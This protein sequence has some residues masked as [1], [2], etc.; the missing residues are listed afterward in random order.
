MAGTVTA[1]SMNVLC[2]R[3]KVSYIYSMR[4]LILIAVLLT[5]CAMTPPTLIKPTPELV[6][7]QFESAAY[8]NDFGDGSRVLMRWARPL[9]IDIHGGDPSTLRQHEGDL[10]NALGAIESLTGISHAAATYGAPSSV[11]LN[12]VRRRHFKEIVKKLPNRPGTTA[13]MASTSA[14][15]AMIFG[16]PAKGIISKAVIGVATDISRTHRRH[17]IPEELMQIMGLPGDAC[18]YRP[19]LIC[20]GRRGVFE[21]QPADRLMLAVLYD[22]ALRPGM[23]KDVAMPIARRLIRQRWHEY[24]RRN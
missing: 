14:C 8:G 6:A 17:C 5:G 22:P 1:L 9:I 2:R 24:M 7:R 10:K 4:F 18:H 3:D 19:S 12:F 15:F 23:S 11:E 20:E 21:M 16:D 13:R